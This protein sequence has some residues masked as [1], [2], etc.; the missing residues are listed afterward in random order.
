MIFRMIIRIIPPKN[1]Y[2][3][4]ILRTYWDDLIPLSN[5]IRLSQIHTTSHWTAFE[6]CAAQ[7]LRVKRLGFRCLDVTSGECTPP[8]PRRRGQW[9]DAGEQWRGGIQRSTR[10][11]PPSRSLSP[12]PCGGD[13]KKR[14]RAMKLS[15]VDGMKKWMPCD[16]QR[17]ISDVRKLLWC[18]A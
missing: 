11:P 9:G 17:L 4:P 10:I 1:D 13:K 6:A 12:L 14:G 15:H 18:G 16:G 3:G 7:L 2:V 5:I 8:F